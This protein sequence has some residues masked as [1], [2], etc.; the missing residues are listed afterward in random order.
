MNELATLKQVPKGRAFSVRVDALFAFCFFFMVFV[1]VNPFVDFDNG[2]SNELGSGNILRQALFVAIALGIAYRHLRHTRKLI[3][4]CVPFST[5]LALTWVIASVVWSV[6]PDLTIRRSV[7]TVLT[8]LSTFALVD[9]LGVLGVLR[10]VRVLLAAVVIVDL[11]SIPIVPG[12]THMYE[13]SLAWAGM[14]GHKNNAGTVATFAS[15]IFFYFILVD[16]KILDLIFLSLSVAFLAGTASKTS[17]A[18]LLVS[19]ALALAY[20][21]AERN[22]HRRALFKTLSAL[23]FVILV[24]AGFRYWGT[25][26]EYLDDPTLLTGRGFIWGVIMDYAKDHFWLGSGYG[27]YWQG[28]NSPA[29]PYLD[30]AWAQTISHAHSSY[31]EVLATLGSIGLAI[32]TAAFVVAPF[33]WVLQFKVADKAG[34]LAFAWLACST[35]GGVTKTIL[36]NGAS[37]E[38]IS[39]V[40]A[41]AIIHYSRPAIRVRYRI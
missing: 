31:F 27:A 34:A 22:P 5:C 38:W 32:S 18:L 36:L 11:I 33:S 16:R 8:T 12:A 41:I 19:I 23:F 13:G 10:I 9:M 17:I 15:M 30:R 21:F 2:P 26:A 1:G 35:I 4:S 20:L 6:S 37:P 3:T 39:L 29:A 7:L 25:I 14:H 28:Q 24:T 40:L